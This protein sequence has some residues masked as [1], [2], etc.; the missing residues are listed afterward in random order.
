MQ[1]VL[2]ECAI[3]TINQDPLT[4]RPPCKIMADSSFLSNDKYTDGQKLFAVFY[5][6]IPRKIKFSFRKDKLIVDNPVFSL[7][8]PVYLFATNTGQQNYEAQKI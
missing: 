4:S 3:N 1:A 5:G 8:A 6:D 7:L 2:L